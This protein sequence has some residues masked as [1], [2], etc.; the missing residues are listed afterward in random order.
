MELRKTLIPLK[1]P[2]V[3]PM[4]TTR[5]HSFNVLLNEAEFDHLKQLQ[6]HRQ[7]SAGAVIRAALNAAYA[8]IIQNAPCCPDGSR[9]LVPHLMVAQPP[10]PNHNPNNPEM[11]RQT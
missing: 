2:E 1:P 3:F 9:C 7:T 5:N 6:H 8:H 4:S 11:D 10:R